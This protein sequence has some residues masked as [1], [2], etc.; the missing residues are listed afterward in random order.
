V[1][2][3]RKYWTFQ[4][5]TPL[6]G[7]VKPKEHRMPGT[8]ADSDRS[9][10]LI[11]AI[12]L[13]VPLLPKAAMAVDEAAYARADRVRAMEPRDV[14]GRVFAHWL[15]DGRR[16]YYV[17]P[18]VHE[19]KGTVFLVDPA[20]GS[21]RPMFDN[22]K[23]ASS[24]ARLSGSEINSM[25]LPGFF[26]SAG[27]DAAVFEVAALRYRCE[28]ATSACSAELP[29]M[30]AGDQEPVPDWAVR[31]PDGKWDAFIFDNNVYV[32]PASLART[33]IGQYRLG[34]PIERGGNALFG[35][36][37]ADSFRLFQPTGMR[38][39]CDLGA[40]PGP[41]DSTPRPV[42]PPPSGSTALTSDGETLWSYGP[43]WRFGTEVATLDAD[44]Y[45]PTRGN[46]AWSP[47]SKRLLTKREDIRGV[48][49][50]PLYSSTGVKPVDH[51]Y[52]WATPSDEHVPTYGFYILDVA[53]RTSV[54]VD[55]P[56]INGYVNEIGGAEWS[57]D[58]SGLYVLSSTRNVKEAR[59]SLADARTGKVRP[60][61][62]ETSK[63]FV[64]MSN[65]S[66]YG[67]VLS[68]QNDGEDIFWFS[69]RDGWGHL[70]RYAQDGTLKNQVDK[71][72]F[73][74]A[75]LVR[76]DAP[77][78]RLYFTARDRE[79][80][81]P[82]YRHLYRIDF[83]GSGL[84]LLTPEAGDHIIQWSPDGAY[85]L[86]TV[87]SIETPPVTTLRGADGKVVLTVSKGNVDALKAAGWRAA[88]TFTVKARDGVTDLFGVMYKPSNFDPSKRYPVVA[89]IYP[90]PFMGGNGRSW[91]FQGPDNAAITQE[92][93]S[94]TRHGEGMGQSLA[95]LG[96]IV[97]K[98]D[99]M[100]TAH[101]SKPFQDF[102]YGN[103]FD[104]GLPDQVSAIEQL[105]R[106]F[107]FI[108]TSK[109][110][111]FG[112]SGGGYAAAAG[113]LAFPDTFKVGVS[114][115]GN[116]D[117][118]S[119]AWFWGERYQGPLLSKADDEAYVAAANITYAANLK[120]KLLLIHGDMDCNNPQAE[121][122]RLADA[123]MKANKDFDMLIVPDHGHALPSYT[124]RRTWDYFV[125]NLRG[126]EPPQQYRLLN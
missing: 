64:E 86:D 55:V 70:Y 71:G 27:E 50:Y 76:V 120:G 48:G 74:I 101:R 34:R 17:S 79:P 45:K 32:R 38:A 30:A 35:Q 116:H 94:T 36:A 47:D 96:F 21:K 29:A 82:V 14:G 6:F 102:F 124:I 40:P 109:V 59:F 11:C 31:S 25:E 126:E 13:A 68:V 44:R 113:M 2:Q 91:T 4:K 23:V 115:S 77:H 1:G 72:D 42:A 41:V 18:G 51:S 60:I 110:G 85:F 66:E 80:G 65:G 46:F 121:T 7:D 22:A 119:Y 33:E 111:I 28:L 67:T 43:R 93:P 114:E 19:Q 108:D 106:R 100:G 99:A 88:E 125:K 123:L 62:R 104:N 24:L 9:R 61:I 78:R 122:L 10:W 12:L 54:R 49:I 103:T 98:L 92:S 97:I 15:K 3:K 37:L 16:F 118:R 58:S 112:H 69:E 73:T 90:G 81:I 57:K 95:E 83:D 20:K 89:N 52:Y 107:S 105:G 26:L 84:T 39:N 5:N 63:T 117:I 53:A 75:E 87:Q 56:P 8:R